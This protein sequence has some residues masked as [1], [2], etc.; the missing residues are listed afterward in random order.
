MSDRLHADRI[1]GQVV[2]MKDKEISF[3]HDTKYYTDYSKDKF[4]GN[5]HD[6]PGNFSGATTRVTGAK[7]EYYSVSKDNHQAIAKKKC[8]SCGETDL[9]PECKYCPNCGKIFI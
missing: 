5:Y 4:Q 6:M 8:L 3:C 9:K 2:I 1:G 7:S